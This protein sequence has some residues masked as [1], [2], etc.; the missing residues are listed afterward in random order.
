MKTKL[1]IK[2]TDPAKIKLA[3]VKA[4]NATGTIDPI[5]YE[6]GV[7]FILKGSNNNYYGIPTV[8][9]PETDT[10]GP[11]Y[12]I[13]ETIGKVK[14]ELSE[15]ENPFNVYD[16]DL[17]VKNYYYPAVRVSLRDDAVLNPKASYSIKFDFR[18]YVGIENY[19]ADYKLPIKM[20]AVKLNALSPVKLLLSDRY[21]NGEFDIV[22]KDSTVKAVKTVTL[23]EASEKLFELH[24]IGI[25]RWA[26]G[27]KD[28]KIPAGLKLGG[29]KTVK[30]SITFE[31]NETGKANTTVSL[32]V[33]L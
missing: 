16:T 5:R 9:D 29:S 15:E 22:P 17:I 2:W 12:V 4:A 19:S 33:N 25:G 7:T 3:T 13:T 14:R 27:F 20:A 26:I 1:N 6:S 31:C 8:Y 11:G 18:T 30:L 23:D 24:E 32:K 28:N 10:E 21:S